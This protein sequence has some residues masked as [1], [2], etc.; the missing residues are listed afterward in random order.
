M[1]FSE[2]HLRLK[3]RKS[4]MVQEM[5]HHTRLTREVLVITRPL[6]RQQA[7]PHN[8]RSNPLHTTAALTTN[9]MDSN[10]GEDMARLENLYWSF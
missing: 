9:T 1:C 7:P 2:M 3:R 4:R 6:S 5:V 8:I 10:H